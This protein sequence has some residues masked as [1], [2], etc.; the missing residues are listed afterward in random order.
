MRHVLDVEN[1]H[2]RSRRGIFFKLL[3]PLGRSPCPLL[4]LLLRP[5]TVEVL[6]DHAHKHVEDEEANEQE[7]GDEVDQPPLI[8]VLARLW[9][10]KKYRKQQTFPAN[11]ESGRA[12]DFRLPADRGRRRRDPGT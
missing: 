3:G 10:K 12:L 1:C 5:A 2:M 4:L 11:R 8:E 9:K 7:E 6:H